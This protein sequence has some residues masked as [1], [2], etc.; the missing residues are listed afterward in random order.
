M[1]TQHVSNANEAV[2]IFTSLLKSLDFIFNFFYYMHFPSSFFFFFSVNTSHRK[3]Q[4][5]TSI[6]R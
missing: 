6:H 3:T 1:E 2:W 4:S 5:E